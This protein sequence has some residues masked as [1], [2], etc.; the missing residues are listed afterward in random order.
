[1]E[2]EPLLVPLYSAFLGPCLGWTGDPSDMAQQ[3]HSG[4]V[5]LLFTPAPFQ[6]M[7][8][9]ESGDGSS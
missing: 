9:G 2:E 8:G 6:H 3:V 7:T 5:V 4:D 1:M